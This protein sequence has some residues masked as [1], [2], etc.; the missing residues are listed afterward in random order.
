MIPKELRELEQKA[1]ASPW[2]DDGDMTDYYQ[3]IYGEKNSWIAEFSSGDDVRISVALRNLAP[4]LIALWE[5]AEAYRDK[6]DMPFSD[7][8]DEWDA[9]KVALEELSQ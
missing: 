4:K 8:T 7:V 3:N 2:T 5:A 6:C 9:L 1:T